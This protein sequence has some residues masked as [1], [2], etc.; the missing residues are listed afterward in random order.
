MFLL[1]PTYLILKVG[2]P[3]DCIFA[4]STSHRFKP[5]SFKSTYL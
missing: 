4:D 1:K 5:M 3:N 2:L